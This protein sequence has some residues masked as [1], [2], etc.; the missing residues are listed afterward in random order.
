MLH[1]QF[2]PPDSLGCTGVL[3][4]ASRPCLP[5]P[6]PK[7]P[8]LLLRHEKVTEHGYPA[9]V[10]VGIHLLFESKLA[11]IV[12]PREFHTR[13]VSA[14]IEQWLLLI[15]IIWEWSCLIESVK[16][17]DHVVTCYGRGVGFGE[18]AWQCGDV[19]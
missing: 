5:A 2:Q 8:W 7:P 12:L 3:F 17:I 13:A 16:K 6:A 10:I 19:S 14:D 18:P 11:K 4:S 1:A 9:F 15:G